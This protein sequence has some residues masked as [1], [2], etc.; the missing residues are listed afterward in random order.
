VSGWGRRAIDGGAAGA[1][2][3]VLGVDEKALDAAHALEM[4][5]GLQEEGG[6]DGER[7]RWQ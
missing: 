2:Y 1:A 7:G 3:R 4:E 6:G 5:L